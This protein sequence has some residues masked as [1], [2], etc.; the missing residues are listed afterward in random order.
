MTVKE[1]CDC[2]MPKDIWYDEICSVLTAFEEEAIGEMELY[3]MLVDI[4]NHWD[5]LTA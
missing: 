2:I 3:E 5:E 1:Y 4:Q